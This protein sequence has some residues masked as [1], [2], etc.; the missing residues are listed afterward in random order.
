MRRLATFAVLL[1]VCGCQQQVAIPTAQQLVANPS[2]LAEW[3]GKC[4]TGE[5]SQIAPAQKAN[6]CSTTQQATISVTQQRAAKEEA[7]F[8]DA[9]T[10]RKK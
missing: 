1:V 4:N 9:N 3:Q 7:D 5:Y 10:R 2:L 8:Y 6:L